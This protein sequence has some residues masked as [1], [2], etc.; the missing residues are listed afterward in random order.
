MLFHIS[1]YRDV[2]KRQALVFALTPRTVKFVKYQ[3]KIRQ[4]PIFQNIKLNIAPASID[5]IEERMQDTADTVSY[6]HLDVYKRQAGKY[7]H[8]L[9]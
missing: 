3:N 8:L 4:L 5:F 9:K 1:G 6:T 7:L 2:Y